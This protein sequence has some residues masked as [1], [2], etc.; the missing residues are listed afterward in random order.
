MG[1]LN[2]IMKEQ[3]AYEDARFEAER[4]GEQLG[5]LRGKKKK[6]RKK[7]KKQAT[8]LYST[9]GKVITP[10]LQKRK[11]IRRTTLSVIAAI[12]ILIYVPGFFMTNK[13]AA[14]SRVS[15]DTSAIRLN[16]SILRSSPDDDFDGDGLTNGVEME[17]QTN[18]WDIDTD[19]DGLMDSYEVNIANTDPV[20]QD[21]NI[22]DM[23]TRLDKEKGK[24]VSSPYKIDNVIL[25]AEDYTSKAKG[26]VVETLKGYRICGFNGY[27]Q[28][29]DSKGKYAYKI[30]DGVHKPLEYREKEDVWRVS[31]GDYIELFNEPLEVVVRLGFLNWYTY[32]ESSKLTDA[33]A[34]ILP[35]KGIITA[36]K[37]M[38]I[39]AEP[40]TTQGEVA[41]V[42]RPDFDSNDTYRFTVNTVSLDN[43]KYVLSTIKDNKCCVAVSLYN[44]NA[45]EYIGVIYGYDKNG[46]LYVADI[47]TLKPS[48]K[49]I[50]T[51]KARKIVDGQGAI[52][53]QIYF[54][55]EGLGFSSGNGDRISF[56]AASRNTE[57]PAPILAEDDTKQDAVETIAP[58]PATPAD[59]N[60][61]Q[62]E[63]G[64]DAISGT[65][66]ETPPEGQPTEAPTET[67]TEAPTETPEETPT[68]TPNP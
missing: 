22:I 30:E 32:V 63:T 11:K 20:R 38:K 61:A 18:P 67:P 36:K 43:Y 27:A 68:A 37:M 29:P 55:W 31:D 17:K 2:K 25:W 66:T 3:D 9:T 58:S 21:N 16:N 34:F 5:A 48:G 1:R 6:R 12:L 24:S 50:V 28:F 47:E 52:I 23:Q 33:I 14:P 54:D 62:A 64:A 57:N 4:N 41:N 53:S 51:E 40:D 19:R 7:E 15:T 35:D 45:G 13:K 60:T 8:P 26:S 65:P 44:R 39:D 49:I 10:E 56:F 59:N 46:D 42:A